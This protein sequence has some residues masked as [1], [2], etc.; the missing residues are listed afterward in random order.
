MSIGVRIGIAV[1][2][3]VS[4][5]LTATT[6]VDEVLAFGAPARTAAGESIAEPAAQAPT[7]A[8][9]TAA[10]TGNVVEV[11]VDNFSFSPQ[12][13]TIKPG[14]TVI[15]TNRDD[16]PHTVVSDDKVFKSKVLDTDEKF[17]FT[18]DKA[19]SF[20]YFCSVHPKMTGKVIV[21]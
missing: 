3:T 12:T 2:A 4:C 13:I 19:G 11:K 10:Q 1:L 14:T 21:Q 7:Q 20:P 5:A 8:A 16:I 15:W 18:F 6:G 9:Q 17:S